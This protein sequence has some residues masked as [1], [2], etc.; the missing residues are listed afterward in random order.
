MVSRDSRQDEIA[1]RLRLAIAR[2]SRRLRQESGHGLTPSLSSA[3]ATIQAWGPLTPSELAERENV[4]RTGVTRMIRRLEQAGLIAR[5]RDASDGRSY[6][7]VITDDGTALLKAARGRS[8][9]YLARALRT[10]PDDERDILARAAEILERLL[11][12]TS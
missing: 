12:T 2:T 5:E 8:K 7:V 9:A 1:A 4:A 11:D 3:L 10:L 6:R